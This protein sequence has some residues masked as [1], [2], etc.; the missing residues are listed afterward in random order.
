MAD[1][2][3]LARAKYNIHRTTTAAEDTTLTE[4]I[5]ACSSAIEKYCRRQFDS[6]EFD[7]LYPG[8]P[9]QS[10]LLRHFPLTKV[11]RVAYDPTTVLTVKNTAASTN[12]RATVRVTATGLELIRVASGTVTTDTTVT[13][14]GNATLNAV[15]SAVT[16][17]GNG[18][19]GQVKGSYGSWRSADLR[20]F[21]GHLNALNI[22]AP[23]KIHLQE[24]TE[25]DIDDK[26]GWLIRGSSPA[27]PGDNLS[28]S[29]GHN[30]WRVI[31]TAGWSTVPEDVQEACAEWV[32]TLFWQTKRDPGSI[33]RRTA[34]VTEQQGKIEAMIPAYVRL[35]LR[36]YRT[37]YLPLV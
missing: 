26:R 33:M 2:I 5:K 1:L 8:N 13:W 17:L 3:T 23:L 22:E 14:A 6:Q 12:Q 16:A 30:Y 29:G 20:D 27:F 18:W 21:Q 31:Y 34:D 10:L 4:L 37:N 24:L 7:E 28:W 35:L 36:P 15:A 19:L 32:A 9:S 25:Y 11:S